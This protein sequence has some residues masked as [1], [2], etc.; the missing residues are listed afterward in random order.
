MYMERSDY[1]LALFTG[2]GGG[3]AAK[4]RLIDEYQV[5]ICRGPMEGQLGHFTPGR[6]PRYN[7]FTYLR[8]L[9]QSKKFDD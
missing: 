4:R 2:G 9:I 8:N 7:F 1:P 3:A 6:D 5:S